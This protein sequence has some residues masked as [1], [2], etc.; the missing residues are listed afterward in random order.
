M[1]KPALGFWLKS[2]GNRNPFLKSCREGRK[3]FWVTGWEEKLSWACCPL[4]LFFQR[5]QG[6]GVTASP[7]LYSHVDCTVF[8]HP[9]E[10][11]ALLLLEPRNIAD[12]DLEVLIFYPSPLKCCSYRCGPPSP[13][14]EVLVAKVGAW[15]RLCKDPTKWAAFPF[16]RLFLTHRLP[17]GLKRNYH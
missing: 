2:M 1:Q 9:A 6:L 15:Q 17:Y 16:C 14:Y 13:T 7:F 11:A 4:S 12:C 10:G 5:G 8:R 3:W